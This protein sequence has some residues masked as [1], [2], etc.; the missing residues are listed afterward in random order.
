MAHGV[1]PVPPNYIYVDAPTTP[2][3]LQTAFVRSLLERNRTEDGRLKLSATLN[4]HLLGYLR[5]DAHCLTP[6]DRKLER[7]LRAHTEAWAEHQRRGLRVLTFRQARARK[8]APVPGVR[9]EDGRR[10]PHAR[11]ARPVR[12]TRTAAVRGSPG[13]SSSDDDPHEHDLDALRGFRAASERMF[14]HIGR[15]FAAARAA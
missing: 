10:A 8:P 4:G 1:G 11:E 7:E 14:V 6:E 5:S 2:E 12:R 9:G 15:R 3:L 13:S